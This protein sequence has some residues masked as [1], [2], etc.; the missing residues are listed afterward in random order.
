MKAIHYSTARQNFAKLM[1]Q[2]CEEHEPIIITRKSTSNNVVIMSLEDFNSVEETSYL[3]KSPT[4][5]KILRESIMQF[6][7]GK[8][9]DRELI[10]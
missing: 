5:A 2:V 1:N 4:N 8:Y 6:K 9:Q 10:E 7:Q 3:L